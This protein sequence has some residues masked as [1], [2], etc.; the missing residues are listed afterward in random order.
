MKKILFLILGCSFWIVAIAQNNKSESESQQ[1]NIRKR[2][3]QSSPKEVNIIKGKTATEPPTIV[4]EYPSENLVTETATHTLQ[5]CIRSETKLTDIRLLVDNRPW[6]T[7]DF[8]IEPSSDS[9]Y[10]FE[11]RMIFTT[12]DKPVFL[13][14][15]VTNQG[16]TSKSAC[17]I[18]VRTKGGGD[19]PNHADTHYHA[20][21]IAAQ[22]YDDPNI[23]D[24]QK[25]I[26]D[27]L[28]FQQVLETKYGFETTLL[29][30][31]NPTKSEIVNALI[32]LRRLTNQDNLL[33]Y[34]GGHGKMDGEEGFW[35]PRN[36]QKQDQST[37]LSTND[38]SGYLKKIPAKHSLVIVDACYGGTMIMRDDADTKTC[39][40]KGSL[41]SRK[42]ITSGT[43]EVVPDASVFYEIYY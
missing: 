7:R 16:G 18:E 19:K 5:A 35:I 4:W 38:I 25:P 31:R 9:N 41:M 2:G 13:T 36:A 34:Y 11:Q 39:E 14:L 29:R 17:S 21:L 30:M 24:L 28:A 37:W 43:K 42:A 22:D 8:V 6:D 1:V 20:L 15:C 32:K 27:A 23:K 33:I 40:V 3:S 26:A 12:R 10:K